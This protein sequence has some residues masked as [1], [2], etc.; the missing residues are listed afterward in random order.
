MWGNGGTALALLTSTLDRDGW[1]ASH[2]DRFAQGKIVP[3]LLD[4]K[5]GGLRSLFGL[6]GEVQNL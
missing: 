1:S 5:L 4:S 6:M 2:S 3:E